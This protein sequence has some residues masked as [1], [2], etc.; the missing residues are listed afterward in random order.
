MKGKEWLGKSVCGG[1]LP[2]VWIKWLKAMAGCNLQSVLWALVVM[3]S[4]I[5][6]IYIHVVTRSIPLGDTVSL[7][8]SWFYPP[9]PS[10]SMP[11]TP[12]IYSRWINMP[13]YTYD[14]MWHWQLQHLP[15]FLRKSLLVRTFQWGIRASDVDWFP[16]FLSL[17]TLIYT[18]CLW[19][20]VC[21][22]HSGAEGHPETRTGFTQG[23]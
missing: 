22:L 11:Q 6:G 18:V 17:A 16:A 8:R 23:R 14:V 4:G 13:R 10:A 7:K 19:A 21:P 3:F 1:I 15:P 2:S 20:C 5:S 12:H 9:Y